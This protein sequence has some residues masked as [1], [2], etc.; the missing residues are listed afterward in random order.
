[1]AVQKKSTA[2]VANKPTGIKAFFANK[3]AM[4]VIGSLVVLILLGG[5][6]GVVYYYVTYGEL[7]ALTNSS[8]GDHSCNKNQEWSDK[9]H[10]CTYIKTPE[11]GVGNV[12]GGHMC[13]DNNGPRTLKVTQYQL[14]YSGPSGTNCY[15]S[16]TKP[17]S[18]NSAV[19]GRTRQG[20]VT[21]CPENYG[22]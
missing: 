5:A 15:W 1:M 8:A 21:G 16:G 20:T 18:N 11:K 13:K 10:K 7:P 12:N 6:S 22:Q 4:T 14:C 17:N 9:L 19:T 2:Y 3:A